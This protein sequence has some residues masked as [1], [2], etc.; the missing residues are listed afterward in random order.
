MRR[1]L[2]CLALMV[3]AGIAGCGDMRPTDPGRATGGGVIINK[4]AVNPLVGKWSFARYLVDDAGYAH[5]SQTVWEFR[6][7]GGVTRTLY[8]DNISA[9]VG[10][11]IVAN[12]TWTTS[13]G[14]VQV[15]F[16]GSTTPVAY[17]YHF[18]GDRLVLA[19]TAFIRLVT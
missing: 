16:E 17:D 7:G 9:G 13:G 1:S 11:V 15:L 4:P 2:P 14:N 19:G 6:T 10:D 12:G 5:L 8:S 18:E 3:V